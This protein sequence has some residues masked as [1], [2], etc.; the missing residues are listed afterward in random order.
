M[1]RIKLDIQKFGGNYSLSASV[2]S[3]DIA[4]NRSTIRITASSSTTNDT[5]NMTGDA[6]INGSYNGQGS[7]NLSAQYIYLNYWDTKTVSWDITVTHN[8]DGTCNTINIS[9]YHYITDNTNGWT[10][11]TIK[12]ATI[13]RHFTQTP[14]VEYQSATTTS[15]SFKWTTSENAS[16]VKYILDSGSETSCFSGDAKTGTFSISGLTAKT[17]H[18]LKIK[19]QRKDSGLWSDGNTITFS[20]SSK[21]VRIRVN[22]AWK[23]ATPYVRVNGQW[24]V[25]VPYTRVSG[26]WKKG[27]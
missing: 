12:P 11:T 13:P 24:K 2:I 9:C 26:Q 10:S 5:W 14:K 7:G 18:T 16:A 8:T 23:D 6:Y 17:S 21:T 19:A 27:K 4:N 1:N 15:A 25:A 22:G 3:Q 20:T